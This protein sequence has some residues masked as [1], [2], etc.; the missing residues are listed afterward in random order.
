MPEIDRHVPD[1]RTALAPDLRSMPERTVRAWT[2]RMAVSPLDGRY[3]VHSESGATYVVDP[4]AGTCTCPDS[5]LRGEVCKHR[6]RVAIEITTGRVP[7]PG[8]RRGT[9]RGCGG[10]RFLPR[11]APPLCAACRPDEGAVAVDRETGDRLVVRGVLAGQADAVEVEAGGTVADYP[12][13][14]GYP[15]DDPVV[16]AVYL[17]AI[18]RGEPRTYR[19]PLSR[20]ERTGERLA[21]TDPESRRRN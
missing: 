5:R 6:R 10:D 17:G 13:N 15:A 14:D 4:A 3:A 9:C 11:E 12:T 8:E 7:P 19:F 2:E 16:E 1:S 20:L 21:G 18:R